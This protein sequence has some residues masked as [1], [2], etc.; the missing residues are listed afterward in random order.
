MTLR[1]HP[2]VELVVGAA[3]SGGAYA[4]LDIRLPRG[5]EIPR[6]VGRGHSAVVHVLGGAIELREDDAAPRVV[7][8][9]PISLPDGR[10]IALRVVEPARLL[11]VVVPAGA[12][13]LI[14]AAAHPDA[15]ADDR[16]AL[17]AAAGITTLPALRP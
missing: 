6:H 15:L 14:P 2:T 11:A 1:A 5:L 3:G 13:E 12:A 10:P 4:V 7:D 8:S 17:L 9:G 16:S